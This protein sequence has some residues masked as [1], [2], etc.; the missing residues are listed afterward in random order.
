MAT[1]AL[2]QREAAKV[3]ARAARARHDAVAIDHRFALDR[4]GVAVHEPFA[5][6]LFVLVEP[7][8]T[9]LE[10]ALAFDRFA[11]FIADE[12]GGERRID[13]HPK[14]HA[15]AR[16]IGDALAELREPHDRGARLLVR[17]FRG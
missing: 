13:H 8:L 9:R 6:D 11:R 5:G 4:A 16:G 17:G 10:D 12:L 7:H 3:T 15:V 2:L 1:R 14:S